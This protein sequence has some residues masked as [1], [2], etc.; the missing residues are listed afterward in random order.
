MSSLSNQGHFYISETPAGW[1]QVKG[2]KLYFRKKFWEREET[3]SSVSITETQYRDWDPGEKGPQ[4]LD[5]GSQERAGLAT[6]VA[7]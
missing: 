6:S 7:L 3:Q 2:V 4:V 5:V 1:D